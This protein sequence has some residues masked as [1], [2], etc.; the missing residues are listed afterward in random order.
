M[1]LEGGLLLNPY[2]SPKPKSA[3]TSGERPKRERVLLICLGAGT[4]AATAVY[5]GDAFQWPHFN[6]REGYIGTEFI[7]DI[8]YAIN[9]P[10]AIHIVAIL[11]FLYAAVFTEMLSWAYRTLFPKR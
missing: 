1:P 9:D 5:V 7:R 6:R 3:D 8:L 4:I 2:S 10:Y 11:W